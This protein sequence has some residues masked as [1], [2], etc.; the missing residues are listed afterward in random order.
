VEIARIEKELDVELTRQE[1]RAQNARM[2][3]NLAGI[4]AIGA[5]LRTEDPNAAAAGDSRIASMQAERTAAMKRYEDT[6]RKI[7]DKG[8]SAGRMKQVALPRVPPG[9]IPVPRGGGQGT[10]VVP[11]PR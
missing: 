8:Q 7:L 9:A 5:A 2:L 10:V 3:S 6:G 1:E 11:G 4:V